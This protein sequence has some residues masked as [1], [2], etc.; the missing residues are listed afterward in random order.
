M[1]TVTYWSTGDGQRKTKIVG[2]AGDRDKVNVAQFKID[3]SEK[4]VEA[5]DVVQICTVPAGTRVLGVGYEVLTVEGAACT[6]DIGDGAN[7]N[8]WDDAANLNSATA[9]GSVTGT[10]AYD[11]GM[12]KLYTSEDTIDLTMDDAADAAIVTFQIPYIICENT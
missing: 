10:D 4:N 8:G 1:S 6:A 2:F 11:T 5:N 12:G 9:G 3:F 7:A